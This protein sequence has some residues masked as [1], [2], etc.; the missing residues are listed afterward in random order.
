MQP[1]HASEILK[2][3]RGPKYRIVSP[4]P[5]RTIEGVISSQPIG[6]KTHFWNSRTRPCSGDSDCEPCKQGS[7]WRMVGYLWMRDFE[8]QEIF[9]V[10]LPYGAL[11]VAL[12]TI[13]RKGDLRGYGMKLK[14]VGKTKRSQVS[15]GISTQ[16]VVA[17]SDIGEL[18][19][20]HSIMCRIWSTF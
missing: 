10:Q 6:Y 8:S 12:E 16:P 18:P 1:V 5:H 17:A 19:D 15:I 4:S 2:A 20:L 13:Q 14:R 7:S 11:S 3:D 9:I